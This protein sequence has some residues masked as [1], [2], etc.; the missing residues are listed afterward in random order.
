[1]SRF[2]RKDKANLI[3]IFSQL[4]LLLT[5]GIMIFFNIKN[6]NITAFAVASILFGITM[7]TILLENK[8]K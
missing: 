4:I 7:L 3:V 8:L 5:L 1:M 2:T 6:M